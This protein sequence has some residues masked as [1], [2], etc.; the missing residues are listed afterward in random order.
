[1]LVPNNGKNIA[2]IG[3]GSN[4]DD[5]IYQITKAYN[6]LKN[7]KNIFEIAISS[8]Y[9]TPPLGNQNQDNFINAVAK[10]NT[11]LSYNELHILLK[12]IEKSHKKKVV[13]IWG[14][15]TLDL[16][17]LSYNDMSINTKEL[18]IPHPGV[19]Y[20]NFVIVPWYEIEPSFVLP[21]NIKISALFLKIDKN[22]RKIKSIC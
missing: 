21:N 15:R 22:I 12:L 9:E 14:P 20:R 11:N 5:P 3:L 10:I 1:M 7:N 13:N 8:L 2:F 18:I 17:L 6:F 16:D 4:I 19:Q